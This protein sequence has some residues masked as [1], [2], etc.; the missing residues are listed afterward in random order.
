[1][2]AVTATDATTA[3]SIV[4]SPNT[5]KVN[6]FYVY[7]T[8]SEQFSTNADLKI[9]AAETA[10][11]EA[12]AARF[13]QVCQV[14][15]PVYRQRT[16]LSLASGLGSDPAANA[17]AYQSV[18]SAWQDFIAH[19]DGGRPFVLVGDSQGAAMLIL[20]IEHEIDNDPSLR[21]KLISAILLGGNVQVATGKLEGGS[22]SHVPGCQNVSE[23]GCVIAF[24]SFPSA[25]PA[26]SNFGRPGQGV[27][28]QSGQHTSTGEQVLCT[29]PAALA[30]GS[31]A[32]VPEFLS[33]A[34]ALS[35]STVSTPWVEFPNLYRA[36]CES[37]DGATWLD[38]TDAGSKGVRPL[39]TEEDGPDWGY[40]VEDVSLT[41][42]NLITDV[43]S[44]S[45][46][47]FAQPH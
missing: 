25:P 14:W 26:A 42:G 9:G 38:V 28:L 29:N 43:A 15:A 7:P 8:V 37:S 44:E 22:F 27:S 36:R 32:L 41:L 24:S 35:G 13:S 5:S 34:I 47:Y 18:A 20:L 11:A 12:Q 30:G 1:M 2:A 21:S 19:H 6:C 23:T 46:A 3:V 39:V 4:T 31:A 16:L 10:V 40:H 17:I 45:H 33:A